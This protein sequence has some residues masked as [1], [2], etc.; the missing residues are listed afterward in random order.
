MT[1]DGMTSIRSAGRKGA[2]HPKE[3]VDHI[4]LFRWLKRLGWRNETALRIASFENTGKGLYSRK[5]LENGDCLIELPYDAMIGLN[6][7]EQDDDFRNM[8]D[9][10]ALQESALSLE[11]LPFQSLLAFYLCV[12]KCSRWDAYLQSLPTNFTNPY[13]CTKQELVH[14]SEVLLQRMVEQNG[15][16]KSG[17]EKIQSVLRPEWKQT[18][19]LEKFKWA[20][21]VINTRSVFLD[22]MAVKMI[23]SFLPSGSL[24][25][26][27]LADEPSMALAPFLDFFNHQSGT[28]TNS[29]LSLSIAQIRDRLLNEKPLEL[30]YKLHTDTPYRPGR[31]IFISY[32]TH[33]NTKLLLEYGFFIPSNPDDFV[34]L[35]I[36]TI[37]AFIKHDPE[38]R[39][40]RLPREKYRFL[41]DHHLDEQLFFV[42]DDLLSHNLA[43]CLTVLFV[44]RNI[45]HMKTVAFAATPPLE[46]IRAIALRLLDFLLLEIKQSIEGLSALPELSPAGTAY[47]EY[48]RECG[49]FLNK[50]KSNF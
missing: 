48:R 42:A 37:N 18:I 9:E 38:L 44:E 36:G 47:R 19:E 30:C 21:F 31:Q 7:L 10:T 25:E 27:F 2:K 24:F 39:C 22:P 43:V 32:G 50:I 11:K 6:V 34:E 3:C 17:L 46:P 26:N 40:L 20:Y 14:L 45:H 4:A 41:A 15:Q 12:T 13:F 35:T 5:A 1:A 49:V 23:N 33:N 29:E 8:F 28:K 16:I